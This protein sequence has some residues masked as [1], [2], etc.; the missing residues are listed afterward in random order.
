ML[1]PDV[2]LNFMPNAGRISARMQRAG[3]GA[4]GCT[5]F[6]FCARSVFSNDHISGKF[7]KR[8]EGLQ[9]EMFSMR[10]LLLLKIRC[11]FQ[12]GCC[13]N[14]QIVGSTVLPCGLGLLFGVYT[15][16]QCICATLLIFP[17][18]SDAHC[19]HDIIP[20]FLVLFFLSPS[21]SAQHP[22]W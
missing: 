1:S 17:M 19:T 12:L 18:L 9:A 5:L 22:P 13:V 10:L 11:C 16:S 6:R 3:K 15:P 20:F 2:Y 14:S 8:C 4:K 21:R 7:N